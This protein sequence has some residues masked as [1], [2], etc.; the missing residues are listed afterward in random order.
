MFPCVPGGEFSHKV[1]KYEGLEIWPVVGRTAHPE[2]QHM[3]LCTLVT[4][5]SLITPV[6]G[7]SVPSSGF[8]RHS[9]PVIC[10]DLKDFLGHRTEKGLRQTLTS[11]SN[12]NSSSVKAVSGI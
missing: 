8:C 10:V 12:L 11:H 3:I 1:Y 9:M 2:D 5:H 7:N 6:L 4:A